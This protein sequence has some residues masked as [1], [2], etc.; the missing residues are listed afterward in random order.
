MAR[1]QRPLQGFMHIHRLAI[2]LGAAVALIL[3]GLAGWRAI[4]SSQTPPPIAAR[5]ASDT[6][7]AP[8]CTYADASF[9]PTEAHYKTLVATQAVSDI[10]ESQ[11]VTP[12]VCSGQAADGQYCA[13]ASSGLTVPLY[14]IAADG[15]PQLFT[16]NGGIAHLRSFFAANKRLTYQ[17]TSP[18]STNNAIVMVFVSQ[19]TKARLLLHFTE[20]NGGWR[21]TYPET[22]AA[23]TP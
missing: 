8:V 4:T 17:D 1:G 13:G 11:V 10:L 15:Q 6:N 2:V 23:T 21:F 3:L 14:D 20:A 5:Q 9:C 18:D 12:H 16:R 22:A 7:D 19:A